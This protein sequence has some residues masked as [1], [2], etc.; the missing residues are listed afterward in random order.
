MI[1]SL[2]PVLCEH[3]LSG[4]VVDLILTANCNSCFVSVLSDYSQL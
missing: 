2:S 1:S 4:L 3:I